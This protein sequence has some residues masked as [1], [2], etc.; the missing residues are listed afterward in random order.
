MD[1][2]CSQLVLR[3]GM[4]DQSQ[5]ELEEQYERDYSLYEMEMVKGEELEKL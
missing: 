1:W 3:H 5:E 2:P 4:L